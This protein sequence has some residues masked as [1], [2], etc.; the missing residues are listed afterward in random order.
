MTNILILGASH[1]L[2]A[3]FS[4]GVPEKNDKVWLVSRGQ[5]ASL[6][7]NDNVIRSWIEADLSSTDVGQIISMALSGETL[8]V[9]IYNAGIWERHAFENDYDFEGVEEIE[10]RNIITVNLTAAIICIQ[11]LIANLKKAGNAKIILIGSTSGLDNTGSP[12]VAYTAS[13]FGLRGLAQALR[14]NLR[15]DGIAVTCI[16]PGEIAAE[17][18]YE[19]GVETAISTY[20]GTRIPVQDL[21]T[22]VKCVINLSR[23]ACIKEINM[24]AITDLN[25]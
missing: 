10:T 8:D 25:A 16:N 4:I 11:K 12:E 1:G 24:P 19:Q 2:G 15:K 17:I 22:V 5:P 7:R 3:A 21:V 6:S 14:Q 20:Q 18:P 23:V 9:L 13:K